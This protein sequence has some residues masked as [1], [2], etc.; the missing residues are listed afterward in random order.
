[1]ANGT[2]FVVQRDYRVVQR[3][4]H[5][6]LLKHVHC[7]SRLRDE[8]GH[9][10]IPRC[11]ILQCQQT[12]TK[13]NRTF[14]QETNARDLFIFYKTHKF[15]NAPLDELIKNISNV[16]RACKLIRL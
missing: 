5:C 4:C 15:R 7:Q 1:M 3:E 16:T 11:A 13:V 6:Q 12:I 10:K 9:H 8:T 14:A 2:C